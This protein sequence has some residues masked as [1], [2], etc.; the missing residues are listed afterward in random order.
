MA[1]LASR[2]QWIG[3]AQGCFGGS[4]ACA[5][6]NQVVP[7]EPTIAVA[8]LA[9]DSVIEMGLLS[10]ICKRRIT[11]LAAAPSDDLDRGER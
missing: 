8:D 4:R 11:E 3:S 6:I 9:A 5:V 1:D 2:A 7:G 10:P